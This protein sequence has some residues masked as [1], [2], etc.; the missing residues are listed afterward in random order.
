MRFGGSSLDGW[1]FDGREPID[2]PATLILSGSTVKI[3]GEH[4]CETFAA[5]A[6]EVSPRI[7]Q[8]DRFIALPNG[9]Q[10]QCPDSPLLNR[11]PQENTAEGVAA[12]LERRFGVALVSVGITFALL[13][14]GYRYGLAAAA[15]YAA[16]RI[17][18]Q[19]ERAL[20]EQVL[21]WLDSNH[22]LLASGL[23][24]ETQDRIR[25]GFDSLRQGLPMQAYLKLEFRNAPMVGPNAFALP[26]G[27][28]VITDQ[29]VEVAHSEDEILAVLAHEIGHVE[30]RHTMRKLLEGSATAVLAATITSDAAALSSAVAGLPV[31]LLQ[32]RYSRRFETEADDYAFRLLKQKGISPN[33]FA[34]LMERLAKQGVGAGRNFSFLSSH[35]VTTERI[36]RARAAAAAAE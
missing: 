14:S 36:A 5:S 11:L 26:G 27:T 24:H 34:D 7:G 31:A 18:I 29:M 10:L 2:S 8:A 21:T 32:A 23:S 16:P 3:V 19:T 9:G 13:V 22:V 1:Y 35:P 20:G 33:A 4:V 30:L 12:W 15:D 6:L 17:P 25:D 28:I